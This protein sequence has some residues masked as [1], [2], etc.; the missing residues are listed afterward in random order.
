MPAQFV[1]L[2]VLVIL[3]LPFRAPK[4]LLLLV[5][6]LCGWMGKRNPV[7]WRVDAELFK[8]KRFCRRPSSLYI[9]FGLVYLRRCVGSGQRNEQDCLKSPTTAF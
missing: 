5:C 1:V 3:L 2:R 6:F 8:N 7:S 4:N 9:L